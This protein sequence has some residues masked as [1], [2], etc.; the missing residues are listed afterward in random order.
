MRPDFQSDA[1]LSDDAIIALLHNSATADEAAHLKT[2]GHCRSEFEAYQATLQCVNQWS[3]PERDAKYGER[4]WR[5]VSD[6][7]PRRR[8]FNWFSA[9]VAGWAGVAACGVLLL[10]TLVM[11]QKPRETPRPPVAEVQMPAHSRQ[12]LDAALGDHLERAS[13][14]LTRVLNERSPHAKYASAL[15]GDDEQLNDLIA[16]N[17]LYRQTA[18]QQND[19]Q[20]VALLSDVEAVLLDLQHS[21]NAAPASELRYVQQRISDSS[22]RFRLGIVRSSTGQRGPD[23]TNVRLIGRGL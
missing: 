16:D 19:L 4:V 23:D 20:T 3:A 1:H 15:A 6:R 18:E 10:L 21:A 22:L 5:Q 11:R 2:C 14:L 17:R 7:I 13:I 9:P 8:G 12:L